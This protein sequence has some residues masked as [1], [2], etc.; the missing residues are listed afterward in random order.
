MEQLLFHPDG[1]KAL[2]L[3]LLVALGRELPVVLVQLV[4]QILEQE[5]Q[6]IIAIAIPPVLLRI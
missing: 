2:Y 3:L 4:H 6:G 5:W 1:P